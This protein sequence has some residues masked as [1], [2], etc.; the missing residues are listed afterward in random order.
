MKASQREHLSV[1]DYNK[2]QLVNVFP[3]RFHPKEV[4]LD[5]ITYCS[6]GDFEQGK[7]NVEETLALLNVGQRALVIQ[8]L[9]WNYWRRCFLKAKL[10]INKNPEEVALCTDFYL[11]LKGYRILL[12]QF[13]GFNWTW[14]Q[15]FIL[16]IRNHK[17][18]CEVLQNAL[19]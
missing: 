1:E 13:N 14:Y 4:L 3:G 10:A 12:S 16:E 11:V 7:L 6:L 19:N 2:L 18:D 17:L 8:N 9:V 5:I 15:H